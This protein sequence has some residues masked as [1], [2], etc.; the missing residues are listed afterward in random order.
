MFYIG[1]SHDVEKRIQEHNDGKTKATKNKGPW[2]VKFKQFYPTL[3]EAKQIEYKL[4]K[5]K[6]R[7]YIAKIIQ[8]G[9]IKIHI[10][11]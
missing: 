1:A 10:G 11:L 7:D 3:K 4:K 2:I 6:R 5:L 8:E 9:I